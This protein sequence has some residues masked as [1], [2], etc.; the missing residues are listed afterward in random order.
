MKTIAIILILLS[1]YVAG[2]AT[3]FVYFACADDI[4]VAGAAK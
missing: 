1:V 4:Q 3:P 2:I